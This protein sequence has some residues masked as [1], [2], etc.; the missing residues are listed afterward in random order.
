MTIAV[1]RKC[2]Y[3]LSTLLTPGRKHRLRVLFFEPAR[4]SQTFPMTVRHGRE[5]VPSLEEPE[6]L[7][8]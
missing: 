5:G 1:K 7:I 8:G 2:D 4:A 3:K 6:S